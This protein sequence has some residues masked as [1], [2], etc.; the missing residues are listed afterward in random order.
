MV[1]LH[2]LVVSFPA[3]GHIN[4]SLQFAK[5]LIRIGAHVTF[6]TS[7]AAH[8]RM[9]NAP[10]LDCLTYAPFSDGY[11][12]AIDHRNHQCFD[13][14]KRHGSVTLTDLV[15]AA[16]NDHQTVTCIVYNH[17]LTWVPELAR[18]LHVPSVLLWIQPAAVLDIYYYYFNGYDDVIDRINNDPSF[19][20]ELPGLPSLTCVDLPSFLIPS[21]TRLPFKSLFRELI[22]NLEKETKARVLVNSFEALE[23]EALRSIDKYDM[24]GIG[25]LIPS[26]FLDGKDP[27]DTSFGGD[28]VSSTMDYM[29]W[30]NSK[31]EA[32][33]VYVSFGTTSALSKTQEREIG[34][35]L[36]ECRR[37]F[38]WVV[39]Q[40][41]EN[42]KEEGEILENIE[43][44]KK[45]GM[46][47]P[48]CSQVEVLCNPSIGCFVTH[49]GW[50]STM[51]GLVA[52]VPMV[53]FPQ[54]TDQPTISKLIKD[55]WKTGLRLIS[56]EEGLVEGD[57]LK[58]CVEM[59][60]EEESGED[61][62]RNA[63]RWKELAK[64]AMMDGGSSDKNLQAFVDEVDSLE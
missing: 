49:C 38:L 32:S 31:P 52:G 50:N 24:V 26:A 3:Q 4:P 37:P 56:S 15:V 60:M 51:E 64:E 7:I 9:T 39:M 12:D 2:F 44:L 17:L 21:N 13:E 30:L 1:Q 33:V 59:V 57:E 10:T 20:L 6:V 11:D 46:V 25:P 61:M 41:T 47:V 63:K 22:Q 55:V 48:W 5:R 23:A 54:W 19:C 8:R 35:G 53:T 42:G 29:D 16:A 27:S 28:L 36:L 45:Y 62:R 43:E 34:R 14:L 40:P 18:D 58:R